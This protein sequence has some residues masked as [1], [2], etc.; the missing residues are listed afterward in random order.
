MRRWWVAAAAL[1][2]VVAAVAV[3]WQLRDEG[4]R[5]P[6]VASPFDPCPSPVSPPPGPGAVD[7]SAGSPDAG[8]QGGAPGAGQA[9]PRVVLP[10]FTGGEPI[11]LAALGRPLVVNLWASWCD[12]CRTELPQLQAFA[13]A[14]P[15]DVVVIGVVTTDTRA[16]SASL[17]EDLHLTFPALFDRQGKLLHAVG[18]TGLPVTLFVDA[19]GRVLHVASGGSLTA[20]TVEELVRQH[21]GLGQR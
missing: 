8:G 15:G 12:P 3:W 2:V 6:A 10:C 14:H 1:V 4:V 21:L 5:S 17:G 19:Q 7:Q 11:E 20:S 18:G 9:L 13:D 16:A